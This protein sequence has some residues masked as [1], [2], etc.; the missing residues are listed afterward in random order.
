MIQHVGEIAALGVALSWTIT[1]LSFEYASNRV[2]SL[3]VNLIR[4]PLALLYLCIF[5]Y[6]FRGNVLPSDAGKHQWIW[7]TIS[8]LVGFTFGDLFLQVLY[9]HWFKV[10][11]AHYDACTTHGSNYGMVRFW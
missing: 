1:A 9:L 6:F 3:N 4:L 7:L 2:G 11:D 5:C 10:L 8:G